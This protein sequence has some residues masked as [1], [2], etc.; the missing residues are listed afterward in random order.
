MNTTNR[1]LGIVALIGA[2]FLL[3]DGINVGF[4]E[5][6]DTHISGFFNFAFITG[7]ICSVVALYR[8]GAYGKDKTGTVIFSLQI[9]LLFFANA[10]NIYEMVQPGVNTLLYRVLD[11]CWPL[12]LLC[13][14]ISG[15]VIAMKG[16]L[17]G[18]QRYIPLLAGCWLPLGLITWM[19]L[20]R[21]AGVFFFFSL[22]S[23]IAWSMMAL[24]VLLPVKGNNRIS[25]G[26]R[27]PKGLSSQEAR[28]VPIGLFFFLCAWYLTDTNAAVISWGERV[29][30][31]GLITAM[32]LLQWMVVRFSLNFFRRKYPH[33]SQTLPRSVFTILVSGLT[34][35]F[36]ARVIYTIPGQLLSNETGQTIAGESYQRYTLLLPSGN[37][38]F[39]FSMFAANFGPCFFFSA[40]IVAVYEIIFTFHEL[41][42]IDKEKE[43]LKKA[44]L[45][46]Q[47]D[48]LKTQVNPHFLFNSINTVL[49]LIHTAPDKAEQFL[50]ELSTVYRYLLN[51]NENGLATLQQELQFAHSYFH[52]LKTRFGD[53]IEL[54]VEVAEKYMQ[55]QLPSLTLQLLL[56]NAV[57]HNVVSANRPLTILL[58]TEGKGNPVFLRVQNN[59]QRKT[60]LV[61]SGRM[62]LNNILSK[63]KLLDEDDVLVT[64]K[65]GHFTVMLPLL[66]KQLT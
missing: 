2:P 20:P 31:M 58:R 49:S 59:L 17:T 30:D 6:A 52:L 28:L 26:S 44:N 53:A 5:T 29:R 45:Q 56:E 54:K 23:A 25:S 66:K 48:S 61:L 55:L 35:M 10:W 36:I 41:R 13:M 40:L 1:I 19:L 62:G 63:F 33:Y 14:F 50:I 12:S 3:I 57:K 9:V 43:E 22:Y 65:D 34:G 64:D 60:G 46:S 51:T 37:D 15:L 39:S 18:W 4:K 8:N 11:T 38:L 16:R 42:K 7:W 21:S 32:A 47:L 24:A 27:Q